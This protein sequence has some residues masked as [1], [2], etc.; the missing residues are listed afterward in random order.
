MKKL[1]LICIATICVATLSGCAGN[2]LE[3]ASIQLSPGGET[4]LV[5]SEYQ[6]SGEVIFEGGIGAAKVI[7][8]EES[9]D[10]GER[11]EIAV[12]SLDESTDSFSFNDPI[13]AEG[14]VEYFVTLLS[15]ADA[16]ESFA[17]S[18]S[19]LEALTL[20]HY[21]SE[22]LATSVTAG[23]VKQQPSGDFTDLYVSGDSVP[24]TSN[25]SWT[26]VELAT[27]STLTF[28]GPDGSVETL[29]N[30]PTGESETVWQIESE[31]SELEQGRL[32]LTT[33]VE[34]L[35]QQMQVTSE[36]SVSYVNLT[37]A[38]N[39]YLRTLEAAMHEDG[40]KGLAYIEE[41][42][43]PNFLDPESSSWKKALSRFSGRPANVKFGEATD[44]IEY[45][46]YES[47]SP[48][49]PNGVASTGGSSGRSFHIFRLE[50]GQEQRTEGL[51]KDG[52]LLI[53]F[54]G[55]FCQG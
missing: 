28:V 24:I 8:I 55:A 1:G 22:N 26:G 40:A 43:V 25:V 18:T 6:I 42:A 30:P 27:D 13:D 32:V 23:R 5:G 41:H 9:L 46:Q 10:G 44:K 17:T 12:I 15:E 2:P 51:W 45:F 54:P 14:S 52:K 50:N 53:N 7:R 21:V 19:T 16:G 49:A 29:G 35:G 33:T 36:T 3:S 20:E 38:T 37:S 48:C 31:A 34:A 39:K 11:S 47:S 4:A